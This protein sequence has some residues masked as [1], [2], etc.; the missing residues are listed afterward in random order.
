[1][2]QK[3]NQLRATLT[4]IV[5]LLAIFKPTIVNQF[6][7]LRV[8]YFG[9]RIVLLFIFSIRRIK[10]KTHREAPVIAVL[11]FLYILL[12][13]VIN[14]GGVV[15]YL[16]VITGI[17]LLVVSSDYLFCSS[18]SR[19]TLS[20]IERL[21]TLYLIINSVF[22]ATDISVGNN[23]FLGI[24]TRF[25]DLIFPYLFVVSV[26]HLALERKPKRIIIPA[27]LSLYNMMSVS[28]G[29]AIGGLL[30]YIALVL[31]FTS[32]KNNEKRARIGRIVIIASALVS[33][34]I[35][36]FRIQAMFSFLIEDILHK[37]LT[38]TGRT[39]IWDSAI[40]YVQKSPI[41]GHGYSANGVASYR[42]LQ[43]QA[44]NQV[45][46]TLAEGGAVALL[47]LVSFVAKCVK[48]IK[49]NNKIYP[50]AV[51][52]LATI[53]IMSTFERYAFYPYFY[54]IPIIFYYSEKIIARTKE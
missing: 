30:I 17:M 36:F 7:G 43:W 39:Y 31:V 11:Y 44:H 16:E 13:T 32:I 37:K 25:T 10:N 34:S 45:L 4:I 6:F 33:V 54:L 24:R 20:I 51:A 50:Y 46:E 28:I 27:L 9:I 40:N 23:Y 49:S 15:E 3:D 47:L 1:M 42:G 19:K 35:V 8:L 52:M 14:K 5:L 2:K 29:T 26:R 21:F 18:N 12:M 53:I 48:K 41:L 38:F 22:L